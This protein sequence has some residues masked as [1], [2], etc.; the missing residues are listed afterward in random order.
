MKSEGCEGSILHLNHSTLWTKP[1]VAHFGFVSVSSCCPFPPS[2]FLSGLHCFIRPD[3]LP[4]LLFWGPRSFFF[5]YQLFARWWVCESCLIYSSVQSQ[6]WTGDWA[7][8]V[9]VKGKQGVC[10]NMQEKT[11]KGTYDRACW[12]VTISTSYFDSLLVMSTCN[13][14]LALT[15]K[16][17]INKLEQACN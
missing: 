3:L 16:N 1:F 4:R 8:Y 9:C 15:T 10:C 12:G 14:R 2:P 5:P 6:C 17:G 7:K 13:L 11:R